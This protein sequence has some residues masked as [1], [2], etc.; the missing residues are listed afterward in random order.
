MFCERTHLM[1]PD[2]FRCSH[3]SSKPL[4]FVWKEDINKDRTE[5]EIKEEN[6]LH[7]VLTDLLHA[8]SEAETLSNTEHER[9]DNYISEF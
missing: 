1:F 7:V 9:S 4:S 2:Y 8:T 6:K 5:I 3:C